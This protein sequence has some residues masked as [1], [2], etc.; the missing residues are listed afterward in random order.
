[1]RASLDA[2]TPSTVPIS[3]TVNSTNPVYCLLKAPTPSRSR[4]CYWRSTSHQPP[5]ASHQQPATSPRQPATGRQPLA[6]S[7]ESQGAQRL[8]GRLAIVKMYDAILQD[9]IRLVT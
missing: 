8:P 6:P 3:F 7:P 5:N 2:G 1:M 9:L 4:F